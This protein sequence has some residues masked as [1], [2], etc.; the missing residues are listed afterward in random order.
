[1]QRQKIG[2]KGD[3]GDFYECLAQSSEKLLSEIATPRGC[4]AIPAALRPAVNDYLN[5]LIKVGRAREV[6]DLDDDDDGRKAEKYALLFE[7]V[8]STVSATAIVDGK[9]AERILNHLDATAADREK[10]VNLQDEFEKFDGVLFFPNQ[11]SGFQGFSDQYFSLYWQNEKSSFC[12]G[13][14]PSENPF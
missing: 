3:D 1:M 6:E 9:T 10:N 12:T 8:F 5:L 4:T 7:N 14:A 2:P 13:I 11:R